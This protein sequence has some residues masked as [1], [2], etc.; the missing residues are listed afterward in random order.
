MI[1]SLLCKSHTYNSDLSQFTI[2]TIA[3][4]G[5]HPKSKPPDPNISYTSK[6]EGGMT[7]NVRIYPN[8][9]MKQ[10]RE[11][12]M[13]EL[14]FMNKQKEEENVR[15]NRNVDVEVVVDVVVVVLELIRMKNLASLPVGAC[16][17][18]SGVISL[19]NKI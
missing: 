16:R 10:K 12:K 15:V 1:R 3:N 6:T 19:K 17:P 18:L 5:H 4:S 9:I 11:K 13:I 8:I 2:V 7:E 14:R